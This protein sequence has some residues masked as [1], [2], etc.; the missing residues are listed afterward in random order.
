[1]KRNLIMPNRQIVPGHALG[2]EN[3]N[4][5]HQFNIR[6]MR[7]KGFAQ[8]TVVGQNNINIQLSGTAKLLCGI[9]AYDTAMDPAN[10]LTLTINNDERI[11]SVSSS[12][13][14]RI[15]E[16]PALGVE[17]YGLNPFDE[18]YFEVGALLSGNDSINVSYNAATGGDLYLTFY[19]I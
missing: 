3:M 11:E 2:V 15:W 10:N 16:G 13:L 17:V 5:V 4:E 9:L 1:M 14:C 19:Y 12:S 8:R 18:E 6:Q 7:R